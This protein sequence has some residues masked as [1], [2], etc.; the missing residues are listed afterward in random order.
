MDQTTDIPFHLYRTQKMDDV[1]KSSAFEVL[2]AV[3]IQFEVFWIVTPCSVAAG[4][5]PSLP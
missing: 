3:K 4:Y 1:Q 5:H 2:K